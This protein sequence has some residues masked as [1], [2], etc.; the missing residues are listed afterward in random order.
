MLRI[1]YKQ[2]WNRKRSNGWILLE[3]LLVFCLVWYIMDYLLLIGHDYNLKN[4]RDL[5]YTW[6]VNIAQLPEEHPDYSTAEQEPEAVNRNI[7]RILQIIK[8]HPAV[9]SVGIS[10]HGSAPGKGSAWSIDF[11][12]AEDTTIRVGGRRITIDPLYDF[13]SVFKLSRDEGCI[14]VN[15]TDFESNIPNG[16][17]LSKAFEQ[18][19]FP[20]GSGVGKTLLNYELTNEYKVVVVVDNTKR[21]SFE[22]PEKIAYR[23]QKL[24]AGNFSS[25]EIVIRSKKNL[26]PELFKTTFIQDM[27]LPLQ[28]G[29]FYLRNMLYFPKIEADTNRGMGSENNV[30]T[31]VSLLLFFLLNIIL[32][33][34]GTFWYRVNV[35]KEEIGLRIAIGSDRKGILKLFCLEGL[36]LLSLI[37]IPALL[38]EFQL[39]NLEL[40][41]SSH[42]AKEDYLVDNTVFYFFITNIFTIIITAITLLLSV[43]IPAKKASALMP[44]DSLRHE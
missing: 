6:Q 44:A 41:Y 21:L 26:S 39:V 27:T 15:I 37:L 7:E 35:R 11:V 17:I 5:N 9:E 10:F 32:C 30:L 14:P 43:L 16:I 42:W 38:M 2:L 18:K 33:L 1:I 28:V 3:L 12:N 19:L 8:S 22:R 23:F 24:D 29:N 13:F 40:T 4:Y 25:A 20:G 31:R 34:I 36:C